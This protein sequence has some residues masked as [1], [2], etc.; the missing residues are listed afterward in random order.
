MST[1][2]IISAIFAMSEN[3]VIGKDNK[4]PWYLPADF[5]HF[6]NITNGHPIIMGRKTYES[7]GRPLPNRTN[8]IITRDKTYKVDGC[9]VVNSLTAALDTAKSLDHEEI[10]IIG[11][12]EIYK[13]SMKI[14]NRLY[15]TIIHA[16]IDG[17]TFLPELP[18]ANWKEFSKEQHL[19]DEK[20]IY[21]YSFLIYKNIKT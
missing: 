2:P 8:I 3:R 20:N 7:I 12:A 18:D 1:D 16:N 5:K 14:L 21:D 17:D 19:R 6:K 10:F 13:Q 11:G 4:I 15:L 9:V